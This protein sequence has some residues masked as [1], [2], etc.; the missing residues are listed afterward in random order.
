MMNNLYSNL[1][2]DFPKEVAE[3][4]AGNDRVRIER[5]ISR[6]QSSPEGFWYDQEE[7]EW[8]VVLKGEAKLLF[9]GDDRPIHMRPGDHLTIPAHRRHRVQWTKPDEP[10]IWLAVFYGDK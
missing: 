4:L 1:S 9:E 3:T 2:S 8:V 7:H 6:G 5:I 10:T